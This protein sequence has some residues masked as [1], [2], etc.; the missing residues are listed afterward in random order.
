M[1][2]RIGTRVRSAFGR[3][4]LLWATTLHASGTTGSDD[5][6]VGAI[7]EFAVDALVDAVDVEIGDG[8]CANAAGRCNLRAAV[9][10]ANALGAGLL[11]HSCLR[12][13]PGVHQLSRP[14]RD[15]QFAATGDLDVHTSMVLV[16]S[17]AAASRIDAA[18]LDRLF[19]LHG[20]TGSNPHL[21]LQRLTLSHGHADDPDGRGG[22]AILAEAV[23]ALVDT[24]L[25][26]NRAARGDGG[27]V[28]LDQRSHAGLENRLDAFAAHFLDNAA[29]AGRGG[30]LAVFAAPGRPASATGVGGWFAD[31]R[32]RLG[33]AIHVEDGSLRWSHA[34]W[35]V[36]RAPFGGSAISA[37]G[38]FVELAHCSL[39]ETATG[40][41]T[42]A[43]P[44]TLDFNGGTQRLQHLT[45]SAHTGIGIRSEGSD[46]ALRASVLVGSQAEV[47]L[48]IADPQF[49]T[50]SGNDHNY[51]GSLRVSGQ[52][53]AALPPGWQQG[54]DP[55]LGPM[56]VL[57]DGSIG[58]EPQAHS[59]LVD[60]QRASPGL[61]T[62]LGSD[63][64]G[65]S[66]PQHFVPG[67]RPGDGC[68]PG[69]FERRQRLHASSFEIYP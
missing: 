3:L 51:V 18:G 25:T 1:N 43:A 27:A 47:D 63:Q 58:F 40:S 38:G 14:G 64:R 53:P 49:L 42:G 26:G 39:V 24:A 36:P 44:S 45:L 59:P 10:E 6:C 17:N 46:F 57:A 20:T 41:G 31:N 8:E 30:A 48:E 15:E 62:C 52:P 60:A 61:P 32:A 4:A 28:L 16:G 54:T 23:L 13:A 67:L 56:L 12:L 50:R 29:P 9:Q 55:G 66:R 19:H 65:V 35:Q 22:G 2:R 37:R 68:D 11:S 5:P 21:V 69:A 34:S 33:G 7:A